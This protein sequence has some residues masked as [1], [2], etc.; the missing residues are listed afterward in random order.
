M[1]DKEELEGEGEVG[2]GGGGRS[3]R[4]DSARVVPGASTC[5]TLATC[6]VTAVFKSV[7]G[8]EEEDGVTAG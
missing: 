7:V 4:R 3:T 5:N 6:V 8:E 2:G 1:D